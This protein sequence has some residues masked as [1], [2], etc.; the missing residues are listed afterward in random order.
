[1]RKRDVIVK[2]QDLA[3]R[4]PRPD[5]PVEPEKPRDEE[6]GDKD[7]KTDEKEKLN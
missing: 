2:C 1:M 5:K 6:P 4:P 7:G 3:Q